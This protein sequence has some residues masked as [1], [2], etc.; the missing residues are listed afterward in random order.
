MKVAQEIDVD[1]T[2]I[3]VNEQNQL[4]SQVVIEE[5]AGL[6]MPVTLSK[7][8]KSYPVSKVGKLT[9]TDWLVF[10][11]GGAL[12][13]VPTPPT[14]EPNPT[15]TKETIRI[16]TSVLV[17][18]M[19]D[20]THITMGQHKHR[21]AYVLT[22]ENSAEFKS[23]TTR[24]NAVLTF[25]MDGGSRNGGI[26]T[27]KN[28]T[29]P[30]NANGEFELHIDYVSS[31][32]DSEIESVI[33]S[34]AITV[35]TEDKIYMY[36]LVSPVT[37]VNYGEMYPPP[38]FTAELDCG[39]YTWTEETDEQGAYLLGTATQPATITVVPTNF[40]ADDVSDIQLSSDYGTPTERNGLVITLSS[41]Q[42]A[43]VGATSY[44][45][46]DAVV[47]VFNNGKELRHDIRLECP[48]TK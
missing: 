10:Q 2:T 45:I 6:T 34:G 48:I 9:G 26:K 14:T 46:G 13:T 38:S 27:T 23:G 37:V 39:N 18:D 47:V 36:E 22:P 19:S 42:Y 1:N 41:E 5:V 12:E 21:I 43:D 7:D 32:N 20:D 17:K 31:T 35:E 3:I 29:L 25:N 44:P 30:T 15:P 8:G 24:S 16:P 28:V 11:V 40:T 33:P 4:E